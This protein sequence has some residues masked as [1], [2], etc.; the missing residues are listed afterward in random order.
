MKRMLKWIILCTAVV[1]V[2]TVTLSACDLIRKMNGAEIKFQEKVKNAEELSFDMSLEIIEDGEKSNIDVSCY[3]KGEEYAY[4][5]VEPGN[6]SVVYRRLYAH[7]KLY[8]FLTKTNLHLGTYYTTDEVPYTDENNLLYWVTENV[9]L[10]TYATML[11]KGQKDTV[12]DVETYRYDF[13][14]DGNEYS[15]WY[16]DT[17]LVKVS[18]TFNS[19]DTEGNAHSETYTGV[20]SNYK[21]ADV[22]GS[23]IWDPTE[24][25]DNTA[26]VVYAESPISFEDWMTIINKFSARLAHWM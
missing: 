18:A 21:F 26:G 16:S 2:L 15:L 10:A 1:M 25:K 8:E 19:T 3:K 9:M 13:S 14:F 12:G 24:T 4:T 20:F 5:F 23:P 22:D 7:N 11:T 17:D 6:E